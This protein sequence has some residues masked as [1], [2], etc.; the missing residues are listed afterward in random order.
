MN[1]AMRIL[2]LASVGGTL[3]FAADQ[4]APP[5][6]AAAVPTN[7]TGPKIAF[8]TPVF[9]FGKAKEGELVKHTYIFTNT[10]DQ[11]LEV[12]AVRPSCGCTTAGEWTHKAKPGETGT[13]AVQL[14]TAGQHSP[15]FKTI[16][17]TCNDKANGS[18]VLQLK[19]AIW[20][21][22]E[23]NPP[24]VVLKVDADTSHPSAVVRI[25]NNQD[26][27]LTLSPP[28]SNNRSVAAELK[29]LQ[30]GKDFEVTISAVPPISPP[31]AQGHIT[32][33]T[34]STNMPLITLTA[35]VN[36]LP[37]ISVIPPTIGL[38][39]APL[40]SALTNSVNFKINGTNALALSEP[41]VNDPQVGIQLKELVPGHAFA[42]MLTFPQG[43][44]IAQ[45]KQVELSIKSSYPS[46]PLIKVPISQP[47]RLAMPAVNPAKPTPGA[48][49]VLPPPPR[50]ASL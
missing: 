12:T 18:P 44:E 39:P 40:L 19:G 26:E 50:P 11:L 31:S 21:P 4:P 48:A 36:V 14:N 43:F 42:A 45:G 41:S 38:P 33:K 13:I 23:I 20:K 15:V 29:T 49:R 1:K 27:P 24:M 17:V 6:P 16:T 8:D 34:S 47:P 10:G 3:A 28:E 32:L 5:P 9:D 46:V 30:P 25:V 7:G 2:L 22:I 37:P 35:Y